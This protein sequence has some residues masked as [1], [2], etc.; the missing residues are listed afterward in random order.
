MTAKIFKSIF[1]TALLVFLLS[2]LIA[3]GFSYAHYNEEAE[4][5]LKIEA[6]YLAA[7]ANKNGAE[8]LKTLSVDGSRITLVDGDGC[9]VFDTRLGENGLTEA[10]NH[11]DREEIREA[12]DSGEGYAVRQSDTFSETTRYYAVRLEDGSVLRVASEHYGIGSLAIRFINPIFLLFLFVLLLA[13]L[14]AK[15]LSGDI[16]RPINELNLNSPEKSD[17]YEE[18]KP[19]TRRL[20]SQNYRIARQI[21]ELKMRENEFAS[22]TSN[23]RE[24]M[25]VIN[26]RTVILSSNDSA[27]K[28]FGITD[29][30]P[31]SVITL[32]GT[33]EFRGA[34][35]SALAGK[36]GYYEFKRGEKHYS[37][38]ASPVARDGIVEGAVIVIID[39]T[40]KEEREAL[41]REFT[42]NVSHE[43]KTPL[44][45]ISGFAELIE[46]GM[47]EGED[48]KKFAA[49]VRK[50]AARLITLVG[51]IIRLTQLDGGEI[52]YDGSVDLYAVAIEVAERL[53]AVAE[54]SRVGISVSGEPSAV[55]GTRQIL[56]EMV[57]NLVDNAIK[58]NKPSGSVNISVCSE[59]GSALLTVSDTGIGIPRD[60]QDRVFERFYRVDKSH[61]KEI[62]GTGLGLSI[63]KHAA[64]YHKAEISLESEEGE[65]TKITVRFPKA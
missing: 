25:I 52:P 15:K 61:S 40:E 19:I 43:L 51:D 37:L 59:G 36:N 54:R 42:S 6:S 22:I 41:R 48:A 24:G 62:G 9:V 49:N 1:L 20:A 14:I 5:E 39:D 31:R 46:Y 7:L 4:S 27:K 21:D 56:E 8:L 13:F 12:I 33:A 53:S 50:E 17:V 2:F 64:A 11:L 32:D 65:G 29:D 34:V 28:L 58:Y 35:R 45:S 44:T 26:S 63:V 16:V 60:K 55:L 47:A 18:L 10:P 30:K 38:I 23:M 3:F 57:Y